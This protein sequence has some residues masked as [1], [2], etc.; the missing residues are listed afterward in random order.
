MVRTAGPAVFWRN[1]NASGV[2][3]EEASVAG[4]TPDR[5]KQRKSSGNPTGAK[6]S[7][8]APAPDERDP[9]L[10]VARE[11]PAAREETRED[12]ATAVF[13]TKA[14]AEAAASQGSEGEPK[15]EES[16]D[17]RLRA[18]VAAWVASADEE[19]PGAA[20]TDAA[21]AEGETSDAGKPDSP[22][23]EEAT[24]KGGASAAAEPAGRSGASDVASS[25]GAEG[26][27]EGSDDSDEAAGSG[28]SEV[29]EQPAEANVSA[30][31]AADVDDAGDTAE[32]A[33]A[34]GDAASA[35]EPAGAAGSDAAD[36]PEQADG[37]GAEDAPSGN[38]GNS[39]AAAAAAEPMASAKPAG[40]K[41]E[42]K[43]SEPT[44]DAKPASPMAV[45]KS[46]VPMA[47]AKRAEPKADAKL[48]EPKAGVKPAESTADAEPDGLKSDA[49]SVEP[50]ADAK[51]ADSKANAKRAEPMA[52]AK[53]A[54]PTAD[55]KPADLVADAKP[56]DPK[57]DAKPAS[58]KADAEPAD[59][60]ADAKSTES[61]ADANPASPKADT[62]PA[63]PMADVKRAE[64]QADAKR[65]EPKA[66]AK[67]TEPKPDAK[68]KADTAP[69]AAAAAAAAAPSAAEDDKPS[70]GKSSSE[71]TGTPTPTGRAP[72]ASADAPAE[73]GTGDRP[74]GGKAPADTDAESGPGDKP[75]G[76]KASADAPAESGPGDKPSGGKASADAPAESGPGD[77]PTG[78]KPTGSR[79]S[80]DAPADRTGDKPSGDDAPTGGVDQATAVFKALSPK[81]VDQPTT[82][83]KLGDHKPG[84]KKADAKPDA[85]PE[86]KPD[87]KPE[88]DAERTS[89]FVALKPLD[90]AP[91]P[92]AATPPGVKAPAPEH[93][94]APEKGN[95]GPERT[96]QQPLPPRPPLDL[97]AELTNTP[98]PP[99]TPVRTAVR[100]VKIWTPLVLLLVVVFAV[101]QAVRPLPTPTLTLTA[102]ETVSFEGGKP[103]MPWPSQG[104]AA[105][106][107]NGIG[108]F[109]TS[110]D[111]KPV[112][113]A[114][115][116]KVMT[117]YLVLRDH[118]LK[119]GGDPGP[120][121]P[122]DAAAAKHYKT[123]KA[124]NESVVKVTEGQEITE[125]EALQAVMLPSANN[126]AKL[127]ARWDTK[128][129]SE[130]EFVAKM[131]KTA[132]ELGM[133]NTH[134]T[135]PS[136]LDKTT[137][138]TAEDLVKLGRAAMEDPVFNEISRQPSYKDL[139]GDKQ[140][141][142]FGLVPTVAIGIK[143]G[144]TTA[145]GGNILFAA[146]KKIGGQTRTIIG[147]ALGQYGDN[148]VANIDEVTGVTR[149]LIEAGQG[150]LKA[151]TIVKKGDVV[152]E[153]DDGLGGTTPVVATKDVKAAGWS[154]LTVKLKLG[155]KAGSTVPHSAK[156][157][158]HVGVLSVGDGKDG[159]VEVPVA[160]QKDLAEPGLG[161]KLTRVG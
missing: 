95:V 127:L 134:Y 23:T 74:T 6:P 12:Q 5:S 25:A 138:S 49:G 28:G 54:E 141:N 160:L 31:G 102:K 116:A 155:D 140:N 120:D 117:V 152:G 64:P 122:V 78:D 97:L 107:V 73:S 71:T 142:F 47:D 84:A 157:G 20:E 61:T 137:V 125:Y 9:R 113:I 158:T 123:G 33:D 51:L 1:G 36:E 143:T 52:D 128:S 133:K 101:V 29:A 110:G 39:H 147:A 99:E 57:A 58:P 98:P 139:N 132:K 22:S 18:A 68:P 59:P 112:P 70:G 111:Q 76:G 19:T 32:A 10:A 24:G 118:P 129:D 65:A 40:P 86:A 103:S 92:P 88:G 13:S 119:K 45:A 126:I 37:A 96:T 130:D 4:E 114:S 85:K 156:A 151:K 89:K 46:A 108:T 83:L 67:P 90:G 41:A 66:D 153:V 104:Q 94:S 42:A 8:P 135:D 148:G 2:A 136:G 75:S 150:A 72:E 14:V 62:E 63:D 121:I 161:A 105:M 77:K 7:V 81:G 43:P 100:R 38:A 124:G 56:A 35:S 21:G 106:D 15:A 154:G 27:A 145:A 87:A 159:A 11:V 48:A 131:N 109:G 3:Y 80:A 115:I 69:S 44:A 82:M 16:G 30:G 91:K 26:D 55:A 79:P 17:A 53:S 146:E 50:T 60:R 144:T 149:K 34:P 93:A